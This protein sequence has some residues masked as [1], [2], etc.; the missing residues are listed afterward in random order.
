MGS[1]TGAIAAWE[2]S[3]RLNLNAVWPGGPMRIHVAQNLPFAP[4][5]ES[6]ARHSRRLVEVN[7]RP[8]GSLD[9]LYAGVLFNRK[10]PYGV[11]GGLYDA[12]CATNGHVYGIGNDEAI[13]AA[14]LFETAEGIDI[15]PAATIAVACLVKS[16]TNRTVQRDAYIMLNITGGGLKRLRRHVLPQTTKPL[17]IIG[18]SD[19][20]RV[21]HL[22]IRNGIKIK[23]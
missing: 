13:A 22:L 16:V 21:H 12:L 8:G 3:V 15:D 6:W 20:Q 19:F 4:I 18:R 17:A 23:K 10:P 9:E 14:K 5:Y 7:P 1:G 11:T 2:A